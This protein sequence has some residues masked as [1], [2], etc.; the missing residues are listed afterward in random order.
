MMLDLSEKA[1]IYAQALDNKGD[2][3]YW[4]VNSSG[5][6]DRLPLTDARLSSVREQLDTL[7]A[8]GRHWGTSS[9]SLG[10]R[11]NRSG[12]CVISIEPVTQCA[13]P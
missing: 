6:I 4:I 12:A 5:T 13:R 7:M 9:A 1:F 8:T 11:I 2:P 3:E 10:C